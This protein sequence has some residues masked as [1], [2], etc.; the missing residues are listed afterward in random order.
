VYRWLLVLLLV[1][2][3]GCKRAER[4]IPEAPPGGDRTVPKEERSIKD[5]AVS[6]VWANLGY[7][8]TERQTHIV[9]VDSFSDQEGW[10]KL[11]KYW[12]EPKDGKGPVQIKVPLGLPNPKDY[13]PNAAVMTRERWALGRQLFFDEKL[14]GEEKVSCATCH[15]PKEGY[16]DRRRK[17]E[18]GFNTPTLVNVVYNK[19]QFWDGRATNLE[20]VIQRELADEFRP[21]GRHTWPGVIGRLRKNKA[22][23]QLFKAT[24]ADTW[25]NQDTVG[26]AL[27][28]YMRTL[29]AGNSLHDRADQERRL[30]KDTSLTEAHFE[31]ALKKDKNAL[32]KL[33]KVGTATGIVAQDLLR[34]YKAFH[35]RLC[36]KCHLSSNGLYCDHQFHNIAVDPPDHDIPEKRG[37]FNVAPLGEKSRWLMGAFKTPTLR[38]LLRTAPYFHNGQEDTLLGAVRWHVDPNVR[39]PAIDTTFLSPLLAEPNGVPRDF[40]VPD[41]ELKDIEFFLRALDGDE[42]DA[43]VLEKP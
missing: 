8:P 4:D 41:H 40:K 18:G 34:G 24:F 42:V 3:V 1:A 28:T 7:N 26:I 16:T 35:T 30:S 31:A 25:P 38:G 21:T 37:R 11:E 6:I 22:Y 36:S 15:I 12:N 5:D 39:G 2:F 19:T 13:L 20:E 32:A 17:G 23:M 27:A 43:F 9:F 29:L 14:L 33:G 10:A